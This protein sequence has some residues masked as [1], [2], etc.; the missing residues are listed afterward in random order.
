MRRILKHRWL[1]LGGLAVIVLVAMAAWPTAVPVDIAAVQKGPLAV[2]VDEEGETRVRERFVVSAP[3]AGE[4]LRIELEPGDR[5]VRGKT[6]VASIRPA[7]PGLLD[8][9]TRTAT[10]ASV[11]VA[12][13]TLSRARAENDRAATAL[14]RARQQ[15]ERTRELVQ[16][17]LVP[18][19]ELDAREA[20]TRAAEDA[21]R[22]AEF[23]VRQAEYDVQVARARLIQSSGTGGGQAVTITAPVDG[24]VLRQH[25]ESETVVPAGERLLEIGD[26]TDLEI[27]SDLL[28]SDAVKVKAAQPVQ[29]EQWGGGRALQGRVRLVEPSGFLKIS[30]LGVEEQRVNVIIDFVDPAEA[31]RLLGDAFRVEVRIVI[32]QALSVLKVP[33]GA[34]FRRGDQWA[35]FAVEDG[36]ARMRT[37]ELGQRS[38]A[39]AQVVRGLGEGTQ[40]V[41]YPPDDLAES[42]RVTARE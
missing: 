22:A 24:V 26:P 18:R 1:L 10:A 19:D 3:V 27:V 42:S 36:R 2:T 7:D 31:G 35:V 40:I 14:V 23:A 39:E 12:Q 15:L 8:V 34:L 32:W 33:T 11:N 41:L 30:A 16:S 37:I 6:V 38:S 17:G 21:A 25:H 4:L 9:R 20:E 29:I 28:S 5:V 13:A